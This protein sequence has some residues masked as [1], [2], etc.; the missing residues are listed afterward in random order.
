MG[1]VKTLRWFWCAF[2]AVAVES[3]QKLPGRP[4]N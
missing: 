3:A 4:Q 2:I 1:E